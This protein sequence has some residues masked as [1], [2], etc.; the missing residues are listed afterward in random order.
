MRWVSGPVPPSLPSPPSPPKR[1]GVNAADAGPSSAANAFA[2]RIVLD[3]EGVSGSESL[4]NASKSKMRGRR[5]IDA[6]A[7]GGEVKMPPRRKLK[8]SPRAGD[9]AIMP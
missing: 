5:A 9:D 6:T 4:E 1:S 2:L 8:P 7:T 3:A